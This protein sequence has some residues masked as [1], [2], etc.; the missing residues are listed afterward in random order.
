MYIYFNIILLT[1]LTLYK[2]R[3]R[4]TTLLGNHALF[5]NYTQGSLKYQN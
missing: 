2:K 1:L 5:L 4:L 3:A